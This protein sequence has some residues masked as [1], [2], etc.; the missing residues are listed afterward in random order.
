[1]GKPV[2]A[3]P[4]HKAANVPPRPTDEELRGLVPEHITRTDPVT[5]FVT[6]Q[7]MVKGKDKDGN[8]TTAYRADGPATIVRDPKTGRIIEEDY[9]G[10]RGPGGRES[11]TRDP[12]TGV[13]TSERVRTE[14]GGTTTIERD[15]TT[16]I[17]T[18]ED[19]LDKD[20]KLVACVSRD[21]HTGADT[22]GLVRNRDGQIV[23]PPKYPAPADVPKQNAKSVPVVGSSQSANFLP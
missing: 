20:G 10:A 8:F 17:V 18:Y 22:T 12:K 1:M 5:G 6:D 7:W 11:I 23:G 9:H 4:A 16:G 3:T 13:A 14:D 2:V 21:P 19:R 15:K